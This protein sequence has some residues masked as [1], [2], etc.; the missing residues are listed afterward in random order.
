MLALLCENMVDRENGKLC[1]IVLGYFDHI[2]SQTTPAPVN[3][4]VLM[5]YYVPHHPHAGHDMVKRIILPHLQR[6][7]YGHDNHTHDHVQL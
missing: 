6:I 5:D 2:V 4:P 3:V 1:P 7:D